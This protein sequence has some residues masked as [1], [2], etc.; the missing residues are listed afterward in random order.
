M[1]MISEGLTWWVALYAIYLGAISTISATEI[2]VGAAAAAAGAVAAVAAR[3][4]LLTA[5]NDGSYRPRARWLAPLPAQVIRDLARLTRRRV[6][7][8]Y[9][10][11]A[12]PPDDRAAAQRGLAALV[13]SAPPGT[14]VV[15]VDPDDDVLLV[16]R[17]GREPSALERKIGN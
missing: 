1:P 16:H 8:E 2:V 17:I 6:H 5:D 3:H 15:E 14:Y 7:G 10:D 4:A 13:I 9:G 12:L 11:I